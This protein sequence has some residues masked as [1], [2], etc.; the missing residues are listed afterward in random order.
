ML[1]HE[2]SRQKGR[3]LLSVLMLKDA[4][5]NCYAVAG[6]DRVV[7][8]ESRQFADDGHKAL[9][10][11]LRHPLRVSD[12]LVSAHCNVH[13]FSLPPKRGRDPSAP[14]CYATQP[15]MKGYKGRRNFRELRKAEVQLRRTQH[16]R[17]VAG[18]LVMLPWVLCFLC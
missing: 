3:L 7:S 9:I 11:Q 16:R 1:R 13:S 5:R 15:S 8:H 17:R 18:E 10:D 12:A 2:L 14:L 6:V 4:C